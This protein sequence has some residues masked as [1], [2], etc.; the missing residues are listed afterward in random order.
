MK[1]FVAFLLAGNF[2]MSSGIAFANVDEIINNP[3]SSYTEGNTTTFIL[4]DG[5]ELIAT[6]EDL[7]KKWRQLMELHMIIMG[8]QKLKVPVHLSHMLPCGEILRIIKPQMVQLSMDIHEHVGKIVKERLLEALI[9]VNVGTLDILKQ[10]PQLSQI[11]DFLKRQELITD[12]GKKAKA[13]S[14]LY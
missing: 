14:G 1:K 11:P 6:H 5:R 7:T 3:V 13:Y 4:E 10:N 9:V 12:R 8:E 2:I